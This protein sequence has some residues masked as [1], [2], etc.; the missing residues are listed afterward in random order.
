MIIIL[1]PPCHTKKEGIIHCVQSVQIR[2]FFWSVFSRIWKIWTKYET[3]NIPYLDTFQAVI[4][5]ITFAALVFAGNKFRKFHGFQI[6]L[7]I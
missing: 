3:E 6:E 7:E 4:M 1:K 5:I 2:S